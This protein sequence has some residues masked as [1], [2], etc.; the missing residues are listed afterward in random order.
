LQRNPDEP[1][2]TSLEGYN[3]WLQKLNEFNGD[4]LRADMVKSFLISTEYR[5]RFGTP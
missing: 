5:A 1:P 3:F 4:Y 2:D